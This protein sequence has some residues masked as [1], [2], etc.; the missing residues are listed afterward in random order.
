[1]QCDTET[2]DGPMYRVAKKWPNLFLS[3]LRQIFTKFANFLAY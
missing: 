2:A 1:M 3:E